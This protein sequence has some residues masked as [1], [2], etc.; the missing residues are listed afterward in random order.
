MKSLE[1]VND[2][3]KKAKR[4][5]LDLPGVT[6]VGV[7]YKD[8]DGKETKDPAIRVYVKKK[9]SK[10][11]KDDLI[12]PEI[13]GAITDI[14]EQPGESIAYSNPR[15]RGQQTGELLVGGAEIGPARTFRNKPNGGTIG[16]VVGG[17]NEPMILSSYHVLAVDKDYK[18]KGNKLISQPA[19]TRSIVA[20]LEQAILSGNVDAALARVTDGNRQ[21]VKRG[22]LNI[23]QV[24]GTANRK[25]V[26]EMMRSGNR[27]VRKRGNVT[28]LRTGKILDFDWEGLVKYSHSVDYRFKKQM[29]I[30]SLPG[31]PEFSLPGDSG[32]VVV[33][34]S[35]RIIGLL[36]G[37]IGRTYSVANYFEDVQD[38]LGHQHFDF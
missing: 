33:D 12:P 10:V 6:G 36:V 29:L 13:G 5:L 38:Y 35:N 19:G 21:R 17:R 27:I 20:I 25:D 1:E 9:R 31:A 30:G 2:I 24:K 14:I 34:G 32:S 3:K 7:G 11:S 37:G 22:I 23:P 18:Q 16:I 8:V 4:K 28:K 26:V 15:I